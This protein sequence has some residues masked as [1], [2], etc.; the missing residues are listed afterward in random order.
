MEKGLIQIYTGDGKGKT[1]AAFGLVLRA[2]GRNMKVCIIQF[3][4]ARKTGE[5]MALQK[6]FPEIKIERFSGGKK[7]FFQMN[8][9]EKKEALCE[10]QAGWQRVKE[11][12]ARDE[13]DL[14]ILDEIVGAIKT[15][16]I[17]TEEIK[18]DLLTKPDRLEVVL[19]GRNAPPELIEIAALVTEM[20][21][22]KHPFDEDIPARKG[23]EY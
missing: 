16:F 15:G 10:L 12:L 20:K 5:L 8:D 17:K 3:L 7:F 22:I 9:E 23:I 4:K 19:T 6:A 18:K 1:T 11:I 14:L 13:Y 21:K 2:S